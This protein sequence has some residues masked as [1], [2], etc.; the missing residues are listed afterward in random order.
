MGAALSHRY[1]GI[2]GLRLPG[3]ITLSVL[4]HVLVLVWSA[5][6]G[7]APAKAPYRHPVMTA[8]IRYTTPETPAPVVV[9]GTES[10]LAA[11]HGPPE[12]QRPETGSKVTNSQTRSDA[13][14][15][16]P[17]PFNA[18]FGPSDLDVRAEPS[19]EVLL[20]YPWLEYRQRLGGVVR[21]TL[22][23]NAQG[24]L[25]RAQ[26]IDAT[27]PGHFEDAA[28]EAVNKL[29]FTPALRN[30]R[31]VKSQKTIAVV[32]DPYEDVSRPD[33]KRPVPLAAE[34]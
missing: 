7:T 12:P 3:W 2:H 4:A 29:R 15:D 8:D 30:G 19:V 16:L 14:A 32:F 18:Y 23:I 33:A 28:W 21:F 9:P 6:G 5:G 24:G 13:A 27:P 34:K 22:F 1:A 17:F 11:Q 31:P 10:D 20:R 26:L 25:D